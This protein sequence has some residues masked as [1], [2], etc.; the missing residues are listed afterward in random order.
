MNYGKLLRDVSF[1]LKKGEVLGIGGLA[2]Q[3]QNELMLALAGAYADIKCEAEIKG[4][5]VR[6][7]KP[8]NA[9]RNGILLVPGDRQLE[10]LFL[11]DSL[12]TNMIYPKLA[13]RRQPLFTPS[14]KYRME[15]N[16]IV[17]T[18]SVKAHNID[19]PV[20]TLSG[21]NQQKVVV[22]K[23]LS[24]DIDVLLLADPAKGVD[25]G[26]KRDL[27]QY[28]MDMVKEKN[29]SVILYA[30]DAEE[31]I[32]YCDRVLIMYEGQIVD[33][34][35]GDRINEDDIVSASMR[36]TRTAEVV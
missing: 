22:G 18:L 1:E 27:Y 34:L 16:Q 23:W 2:G 10:G 35:E 19:T 26:A 13:L 3:G 32:Q 4:G 17:K 31:L 7:S 20:G 15:C 11:K 24:F 28:I 29:T 33:T 14:K 30:S 8:V 21:G 12:F 6:L 36:V 25:I 9:V 5:K